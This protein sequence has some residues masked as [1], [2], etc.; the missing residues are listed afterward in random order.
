MPPCLRIEALIRTLPEQPV[1]TSGEFDL[2]RI[3]SLIE[4][5]P[6]HGGDLNE[7]LDLVFDQARSASLNP[8]SPGFMGY[9]GGGGL[10]HAAVADLIAGTLNRYLGV[11]AV[12][13]A[14]NQIE[15]N[16]IRW[17]CQM[18]GFGESAGGFLT[19][20]GS[21]ATLS[22][23]T[24]ARHVRLGE[25]FLKA[26]I[27]VSDQAHHCLIK[28]AS[29][30]GFPRANVRVL[31]TDAHFRLT[32]DRVRDA[33]EKDRAK[34]LQPFLIA[35][36][37]GTTNTG[38]VDPLTELAQ[39]AKQQGLWFHVDAAYGG[40]FCLTKRG[41]KILAGIDA[42]DSVVLDPH[43]TLFLPYGTGALLMRNAK[44]LKAT[45]SSPADYLPPMQD[46]DQ[47]MDFCELSPELTRPFRGLRVWLPFKL[48]GVGVFRQYLD[49]KLDLA[50]WIEKQ[51]RQLPELEI[52]ASAELSI[53]AFAVAAE[54]RSLTR[55]NQL[56]REL[57]KRINDQQRVHLTGT[58]LNGLF[59]IRIAVVPYRTHLDR[60][61]MLLEDIKSALVQL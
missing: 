49:E 53:L 11:A 16:V 24:T 26:V 54:Q 44:H 12:A 35:A 46:H 5:I 7:I 34:G 17:F 61:E 57:I 1:D 58:L 25:D 3:G 52:L 48:H 50:A 21:L 13:P 38:A 9:V 29:L 51:I 41:K 10:F 37:A 32:P 6:E 23:L 33:I 45:H 15:A 36:S 22:A 39:L 14:L 42:A 47:L 20:G 56:T 43:K 27:Y 18:M 28:A 31:S 2:A 4:P 19:S 60:M 55:R 30:A 8:I 59:A 40:F